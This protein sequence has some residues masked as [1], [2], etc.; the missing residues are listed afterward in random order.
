MKRSRIMLI[1]E[2]IYNVIIDRA[3]GRELYNEEM[4]SDLVCNVKN[5][6][7]ELDLYNGS[8]QEKIEKVNNYLKYNIKVRKEYF[9][10]FREA[11]PEIPKSEIKYRT[12]YGLFKYHEAMCAGIPKL[13]GYY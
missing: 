6:I 7:N 13:L 10:A 1:E 2:I 11:I 8:D 3:H 5:V 12:A 9:D 4:F